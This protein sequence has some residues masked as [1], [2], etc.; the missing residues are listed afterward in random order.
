MPV[1]K[2]SEVQDWIIRLLDLGY[3]NKIDIDKRLLAIFRI[4][5][6][7]YQQRAG[8]I[9][10]RRVQNDLDWGWSIAQN[11]GGYLRKIKEGVYELTII[12]KDRSSRIARRNMTYESVEKLFLDYTANNPWVRDM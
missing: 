5:S 10:T 12:G 7:E 6:E 9:P 4:T 11:P 8:R 2:R 1:P 3:K